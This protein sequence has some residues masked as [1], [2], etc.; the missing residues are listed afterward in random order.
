MFCGDVLKC[1]WGKRR[2]EGKILMRDHNLN[3]SEIK[4]S[5][6]VIMIVKSKKPDFSII[7][8]RKGRGEREG[9]LGGTLAKAVRRLITSQKRVHRQT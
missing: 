1:L 3:Q 7:G 9:A 6:N 4:V 5:K 2:A 8:E